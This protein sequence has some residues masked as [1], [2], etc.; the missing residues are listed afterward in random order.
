MQ[1][2]E[3]DSQMRIYE[4]AHDHC[5]L[6]GIHIVVRLDGRSFTKLTK[7]TLSNLAVPFDEMLHKVMVSTIEHLMT[8]TGLR[9]LYGFTESDEISIL[10]HPEDEMF[11]RKERKLN[12]VLASE[13]SV[14]FSQTMACHA[15]FDAR[16]CQLPSDKLVVDYFRWR[17]EDAGRNALSSWCFYTL[18]KH[19]E[20][21]PEQAHG[22]LH[23]L[24]AGAK[25]ELLFNYGINFNDLPL[26]Q[27]RGSG[28]Y[29]GETSKAG[30]NPH[31]N[32]P[33]TTIRRTLVKDSSL[34]RGDEYGAFLAKIL[35]DAK[36]KGAPC[37]E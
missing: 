23:G 14:H 7:Q 16:V 36:P 19:E 27:K 28:A 21:T 37:T 30:F 3:L 4:T 6:P 13:A 35:E 1:F 24:G 26:W 12:S 25:N 10:L 5:V 8:Q 2:D 20:L 32:E 17:Q 31:K 15:V 34:P 29:W 22:V 9:V 11:G 18:I 33:T